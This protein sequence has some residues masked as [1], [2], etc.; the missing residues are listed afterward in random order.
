MRDQHLFICLCGLIKYIQHFLC[1]WIFDPFWKIKCINFGKP[2]IFWRSFWEL[3]IGQNWWSKGYN[4]YSKLSTVIKCFSVTILAILTFIHGCESRFK[5][6]H[7]N[8]RIKLTQSQESKFP[9]W[10]VK[11][12]NFFDTS[13]CIFLSFSV[14]R[15]LKVRQQTHFLRVTARDQRKRPP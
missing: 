4:P 3:V 6:R 8:L 14:Y 10:N 1:L 9:N 11:D 12:K 15:I 5:K 2:K 7:F 13:S